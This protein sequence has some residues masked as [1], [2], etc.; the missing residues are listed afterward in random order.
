M[1]RCLTNV[2][3]ISG[4]GVAEDIAPYLPEVRGYAIVPF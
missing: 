1:S 3:V 4:N 2:V